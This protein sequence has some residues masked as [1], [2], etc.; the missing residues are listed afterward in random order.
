MGSTIR[1]QFI[2]FL[3]I[4]MIKG[5][6]DYLLMN[7]YKT[8]RNECVKFQYSTIVISIFEQNNA[9]MFV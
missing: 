1:F 4:V 9:L 6:S 3:N 2:K 7:L 8:I 5:D